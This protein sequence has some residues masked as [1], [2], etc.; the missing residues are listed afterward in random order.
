MTEQM[1]S[2]SQNMSRILRTMA[3]ALLHVKETPEGVVEWQ[4]FVKSWTQVAI[5]LGFDAEGVK[6]LMDTAFEGWKQ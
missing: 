3:D 4:E 1:A 6:R 2:S 5:D